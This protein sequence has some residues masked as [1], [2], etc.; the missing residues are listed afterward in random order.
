METLV[1]QLKERA[2]APSLFKPNEFV[3]E[4]ES[5]IDDWVY[6][7]FK[8]RT[9]TYV[10]VDGEGFFVDSFTSTTNIG[11]RILLTP[12]ASESEAGITVRIPRGKTYVKLEDKK[13]IYSLGSVT[14]SGTVFNN[15]VSFKT[16]TGNQFA[17][18][19][20]ETCNNTNIK[21]IIFRQETYDFNNLKSFSTLMQLDGHKMI[22]GENILKGDISD[23]F[24]NITPSLGTGVS[25]TMEN[26]NKLVGNTNGLFGKSGSWNFS[27]CS[28]DA[29]LDDFHA[30]GNDLKLM[31]VNHKGKIYG[32]P[33]SLPDSIVFL[34]LKGATNDSAYLATD[35]DL[36][37][38]ILTIE[39][40]L[41]ASSTA[42]D[43]FLTKESSKSVP[44]NF[45]DMDPLWNK[46]I[47]IKG[48]RTSASDA[49]VATLTAKGYTVKF[50]L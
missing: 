1:T 10:R 17:R 36:R 50:V 9:P 48:Q 40:A 25:V 30:V 31:I 44:S 4:I 45:G 34:S 11:K 26:Q 20:A 8:I 28:F 24:K 42:V 46:A 13:A 27:N 37:T 7:L 16:R 2:T 29:V 39:N 22:I 41:F 18:L 38:K 3:W 14:S 33:L 6:L 43:T 23:I 32:N 47:V 35:S 15:A 49:A 12:S 19:Y 21:D 5:D